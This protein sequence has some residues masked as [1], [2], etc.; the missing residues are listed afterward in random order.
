MKIYKTEDGSLIQAASP[1][2]VVNQLREGSRFDDSPDNVSFMT[3]F[4]GRSKV[5]S[6]KDLHFS[7]EEEFVAELLRIGYLK[8]V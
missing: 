1:V 6:G 8:Q 4:A 2:Q 3:S 5:W 7:N